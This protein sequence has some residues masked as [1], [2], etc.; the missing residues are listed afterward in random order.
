MPSNA[1][2]LTL[3]MSDGGR[4][5]SAEP[6]RVEIYLQDQL[7]GSATIGRGF[8]PYEFAIPVELASLAAAADV[9]RVRI[10]S[11]VWSPD[12]AFGNG[13]TRQLG[14]MLDRMQVR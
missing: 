1:R 6:A 5:P 2:T 10:V 11:T 4:P 9:A 12:D 7:I 8:R 14:V 13:D 3:W